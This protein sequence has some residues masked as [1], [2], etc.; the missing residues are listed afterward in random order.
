M[1]ELMIVLAIA[2]VFLVVSIPMLGV[3]VT[4]NPIRDTTKAI[5]SAMEDARDMAILKGQP[6]EV[7][8]R[9][10]DLSITIS[11]AARSGP[12]GAMGFQSNDPYGYSGYGPPPVDPTAGIQLSQAPKSYAIHPE[13]YFEMLAVNYVE[14]K[15]FPE[16]RVRFYPNG[17]SDKFTTIFQRNSDEWRGIHLDMIT[18]RARYETDPYKFQRF[19][20]G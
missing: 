15:D 12:P 14:S 1:I 9:P 8:I 5:L 10:M 13:I 7:V 11:P 18:G 2:S 20:E 17:T 19:V 4:E 3:V 16:A 6:Y